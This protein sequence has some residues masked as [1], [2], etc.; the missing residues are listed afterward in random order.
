MLTYANYVALEQQ[1]IRASIPPHSTMSDR[2]DYSADRFVYEFADR[3][4]CPTGQL[5]TRQGSSRTAGGGRWPDLP[6]AAEGLRG[7]PGQ[8]AVLRFRPAAGTLVRPDDGG[9]R[10]RVV[11]YLRTPPA[12]RSRRAAAYWVETANAE[13]KDR[14]GLRRAQCRGRDKVLI[15]AL[16]RHRVRRQEAGP[17]ARPQPG[18]GGA[19]WAPPPSQAGLSP[20]RAPVPARPFPS[21][22]RGAAYPAPCSS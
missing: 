1:G 17:T 14:H 6:R 19:R 8:G 18:H 2:G 3:Y 20:V 15:Q 21:R 10:D 4:R 7:V 11:A 22:A 13:L 5:L 9:L 12:K 16:G